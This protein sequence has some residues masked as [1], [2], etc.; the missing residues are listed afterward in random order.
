MSMVRAQIAEPTVFA[1]NRPQWA[2]V[3]P[4]IGLI[5]DRD[6]LSAYSDRLNERR[7]EVPHTPRLRHAFSVA[8]HLADDFDQ[9]GELCWLWVSLWRCRC[10][11]RCDL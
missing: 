2:A 5:L 7:V 6:V 4:S 1:V 8:D 11:D 3:Q 10:V 9:V